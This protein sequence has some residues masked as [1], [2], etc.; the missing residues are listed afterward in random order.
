MIMVTIRNIALVIFTWLCT[1]FY[2]QSQPYSI[3]NEN[4]TMPSEILSYDVNYAVYLP[5]GYNTSAR[6]Y[7]VVY[8]LHGFSDDHTGWIQF[9]EMKRIADEAIRSGKIAPM[10]IVMPDAKKTWYINDYKGN[11]PYEDM[12]F[13]EFIPFIDK[14]YPTRSKKEFRGIAGLSMGGYGSLLYSLKHPDV[15][16]GCAAFSAGIFTDD[17][18]INLPVTNYNRLF[19][20][21]FKPAD[22]PKRVNQHWHDNSV[23]FLIENN[24]KEDIEKVRYYVDC[25]DD[26]FLFEGNSTLHITLKKKEINHQYRVRDGTHNWEYWRTGLADGLEFISQ[27]FHR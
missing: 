20:E 24:Q 27:N 1:V 7:P 12:F 6:S 4:L 26:D 11:E 16:A 18:M 22:D 17:E 14:T 8:L 5:E 10:I 21:L 25:G 9:G 23:L 15:F 2:I 19:G 13:K 3:V